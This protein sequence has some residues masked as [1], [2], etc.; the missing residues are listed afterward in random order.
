MI[1]IVCVVCMFVRVVVRVVV[2]LATLDVG[3]HIFLEGDPIALL[4][5][6]VSAIIVMLSSLCFSSRCFSWWYVCY[7]V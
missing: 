3:H 6:H 1:V 2:L 7:Y 5:V 4:V